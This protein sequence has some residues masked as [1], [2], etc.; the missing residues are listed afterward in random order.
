VRACEFATDVGSTQEVVMEDSEV[1]AELRTR[2][3]KQLGQQRYELWFTRE[4]QFRVSPEGLTIVAASSFTRDWLRRNFA[5][6]VRAVCAAVL[7]NEVRVEF[8]VDASLAGTAAKPGSE[9]N[10]WSG[11]RRLA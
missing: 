4:T 3:A 5:E 8:E 1:V 11:K 2:L 7:G 9:C 6:G 10:R